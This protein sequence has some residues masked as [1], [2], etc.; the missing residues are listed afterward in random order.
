MKGICFKEPLFNLVVEGRKTQTRRF[1][2]FPHD[3]VLNIAW[4]NGKLFA[5]GIEVK[6]RFKVG[7]TLYLQEPYYIDE[8]TPVLDKY[9]NL[10]EL[11]DLVEKWKNAITMPE[12]YARYFIEI[13]NVRCERLQEISDEDCLME[14]VTR[15]D[16]PIVIGYPIGVPFAYS[17]GVTKNKSGEISWY[18]T[19][20]DAFAELINSV[21]KGT[22]ERNPYVWVYDFK[23]VKKS[24]NE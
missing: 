18:S 4:E 13:T 23:L 12:K 10:P 21:E 16:K 17:N 9:D 11:G 24:N 22:W 5:D 6:P 3:H 14:G 8:N 1:V 20:Q 15:T 2:K 19:A 7:E